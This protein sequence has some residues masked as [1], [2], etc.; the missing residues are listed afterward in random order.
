[1]DYT[2]E[3]DDELAA[4]A[5][6]MS[7]MAVDLAKKNAGLDLDF[8]EGSI[9]HVE[10]VLGQIHELP[11]DQKPEERMWSLAQVFGSY[12]GEVIRRHHGGAWGMIEA[13][14]QRFPGFSFGPSPTTLWPWMRAFNRISK[15]PEDNIWHYYVTMTQD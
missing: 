2:F 14:G 7:R 4:H 10:T 3:P 12:V 1:M 15:G 9:E 13:D 5:Q 8:T 6:E 11:E